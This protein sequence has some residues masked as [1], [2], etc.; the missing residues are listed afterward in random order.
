MA[1]IQ[2]V[3]NLVSIAR[4]DNINGV[5]WETIINYNV[6][7]TELMEYNRRKNINSTKVLGTIVDI[8]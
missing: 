2:L 6:K 1:N 3:D 8:R 7:Y 4:E 5:T